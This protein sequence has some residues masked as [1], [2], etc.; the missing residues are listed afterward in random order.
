MIHDL[1]KKNNEKNLV[2]SI[3]VRYFAP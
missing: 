3:K 2:V 1:L